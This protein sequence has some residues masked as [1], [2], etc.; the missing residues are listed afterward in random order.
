MSADIIDSLAT[1]TGQV[2]NTSALPLD[3]GT[4]V[5]ILTSVLR[6]N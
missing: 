3:L 2:E 4:T 5:D 1:I 6:Y